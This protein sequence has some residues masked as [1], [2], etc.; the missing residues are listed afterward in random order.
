MR[1]RSAGQGTRSSL[2][3]LF[4][5]VFSMSF[6]LPAA[7]AE[8]ESSELII[9]TEDTVVSEDLYAA[10]NRVIVRGR[11]EGDLI[12]LAAQDVTIEGEVTGS[13]MAVAGEVV[14]TG[15]IGKSLRVTAPSLELSGEVGGDVVA[16][17]F[18]FDLVAE[19]VV[20]GDLV[21]WA[22]D[23]ASDGTVFG[24]LEGTQ[25]RLSISGEVRGD[26]KVSAGEVEVS[27]QLHVVGDFT[28]RSD[29]EARGLDQADVDGAVVRQQ[30]M[31]P[32]IRI[33]ALSLVLKILVAILL[34]AMALVVSTV[35]P[36]RSE[37][38][39][40]GLRQSPIRS[41][42]SGV[43]VILSPLLIIG[44]GIAIFTLA[45][46]STALP[47]IGALIPVVAGVLGLILVGGL[48]AGLPAVALIGSLTRKGTTIAGAVGI[49]SAIVGL[50]WLFPVVGW[51]VA[52]L[53]LAAGIGGWLS[54]LRRP[55]DTDSVSNTP[56]L[57]EGR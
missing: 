7:A 8:I 16:V 47:L 9:I 50:V 45:P 6:G 33:R 28:Y 32:N 15:I 23:A 13:V 43:L 57:S 44:I 46:S 20:A 25:S 3:I 42:L 11:I 29:A 14:V 19:G 10:A 22:R 35:W 55:T 30:P 18:G 53:V 5:A 54:T 34:S 2:L 48:I 41:I 17:V 49:G 1:A 27:D 40:E 39:L 37:R 21:L 4:A 31:K 38:A 24:D 51:P 56:A 26:V 36:E 52:L 12:A